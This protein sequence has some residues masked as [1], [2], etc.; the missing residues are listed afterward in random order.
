MEWIPRSLNENGDF[1]N[2][3]KDADDWGVTSHV[4]QYINDLWGPFKIDWFA[5][6]S[7]QK[8]SKFYSRYWNMKC[9]G[10][11][12][13]TINLAY[14]NGWFCPPVHLIVKSFG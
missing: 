6:D 11:D 2:Q 8:V 14:Q 13:F 1:I 4:F 7:N 9:V 10:I 5:S 12:A 3:L